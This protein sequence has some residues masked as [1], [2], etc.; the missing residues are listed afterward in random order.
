M[1][2]E[3]YGLFINICDL[4]F[5]LLQ[6]MLF[7]VIWDIFFRPERGK[8]EVLSAGVFAAA[9][10]LL[11]LCPG[12]PGW[13][14]YAV[15]VA[16]V[17]GYCHIRYKGCL[18]KAVFTLLLLYNFHGMSFLVSNSLYQFLM[19]SRRVRF[20]SSPSWNT[21]CW[22]CL[23][24]SPGKDRMGAGTVCITSSCMQSVNAEMILSI[25]FSS[26]SSSVSNSNFPMFPTV[27]NYCITNQYIYFRLLI[28]IFL[29]RV[30]HYLNIDDSFWN[31]PI[32][33]RYNIDSDRSVLYL[34]C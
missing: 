33:F 27:V 26:C 21:R 34:Y 6:V 3:S 15:S 5:V 10:V 17:L 29:F 11:R 25:T 32:S 23:I 4:C 28:H 7:L 30:S 31:F 20:I 8:K 22:F 12:V 14:R 16:A 24:S 13:V 2:Q 9:N 18:E 19:D 1:S